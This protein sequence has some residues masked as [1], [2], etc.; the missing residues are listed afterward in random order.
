MSCKVFLE[1]SM[2]FG[3]VKCCNRTAQIANAN[4]AL[5]TQCSVPKARTNRVVHVKNKIK[6]SFFSPGLIR[7][8][9]PHFR[10]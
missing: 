10:T 3:S 7:Y 6:C 1:G 8:E 2:S 4:S 9:P 5:I